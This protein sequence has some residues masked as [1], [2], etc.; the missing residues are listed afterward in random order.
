MRETDPVTDQP[1]TADLGFAKLDVDRAART[2]TPEVVFAGGKTPAET[3][4]C[5]A[6]LV[7]AGAAMAW[8]TRVDPPT[9]AAVR[10]R[11]P[12][13]HVDPVA[14]VAWVGTPPPPVGSGSGSNA[15]SQTRRGRRSCFTRVRTRS[16]S[17]SRKTPCIARSSA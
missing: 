16:T 7:D 1:R 13:A 11:W 6:G 12:D 4:A 17:S 9:A 15:C 10:D 5:L 14:R 2:G 3:V 8:A